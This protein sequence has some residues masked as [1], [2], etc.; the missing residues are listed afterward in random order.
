M[1]RFLFAALMIAVMTQ[2]AAA[3]PTG[4]T[5]YCE[6]LCLYKILDVGG[7]LPETEVWQYTHKNPAE[8]PLGPYTPAEYE[9]LVAA[10]QISEVKL[11]I[12]ADDVDKGDDKVLVKIFREDTDHWYELGYLN[13]LS[14]DDSKDPIAGEGCKPDHRTVTCF[15]LDPEW[16]DGLPVKLSISSGW[17]D[18]DK[19]EIEKSKLCVSVIPAPGALL[20]VSLG[21]TMVSWLRTRKYV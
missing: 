8:Q 14:I 10:N 6:E 21:A 15:T 16:L 20:L 12:T 11:Y 18:Y 2:M 9:A 19:V 7:I 1:K 4:S 17:C 3:I 13:C 5:T